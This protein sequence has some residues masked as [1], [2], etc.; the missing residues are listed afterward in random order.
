MNL[1]EALPYLND[2]IPI[3]YKDYSGHF[4]VYLFD[5]NFMSYGGS[6]G[7]SRDFHKFTEREIFLQEWVLDP[8]FKLKNIDHK[9]IY[10]NKRPIFLKKFN[11][12]KLHNYCN[13]KH[14]NLSC[15][16]ISHH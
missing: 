7:P 1:I 16:V 9:C 14:L 11:D 15:K 13:G 2:N 4:R 3:T 8:G 6:P 12:Y 5:G 10:S